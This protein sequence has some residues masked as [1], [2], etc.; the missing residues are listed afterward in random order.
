MD[1]KIEYCPMKKITLSVFL[2]LF[3]MVSFKALLWQSFSF[4]G[5]RMGNYTGVQSDFF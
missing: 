4:P 5:T 2:L 1:F 3:L